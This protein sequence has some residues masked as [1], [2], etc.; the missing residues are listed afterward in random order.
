MQKI[1]FYQLSLITLKGRYYMFSC[2]Y[3]FQIEGDENVIRTK[4]YIFQK[5]N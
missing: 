1:L 5:M 4:K 2:D 3:R